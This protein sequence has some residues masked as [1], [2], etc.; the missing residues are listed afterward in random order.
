[1]VYDIR[2][3]FAILALPVTLFVGA[4]CGLD[5]LATEHRTH[6]QRMENDPVYQ[7]QVLYESEQEDQELRDLGQKFVEGWVNK[8]RILGLDSLVDY[9]RSDSE[10]AQK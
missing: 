10:P 8:H 1:M 5:Y 6:L 9:L 4:M 2:R 7:T 3:E